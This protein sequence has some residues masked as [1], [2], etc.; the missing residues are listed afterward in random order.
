M[1]PRPWGAADNEPRPGVNNSAALCRAAAG[2]ALARV[3][4]HRGQRAGPCHAPRRAPSHAQARTGTPL[5]ATAAP[6]R[7]EHRGCPPR[8]C[9]AHPVTPSHP[10]VLPV[11]PSHRLRHFL[12]SAL[13]TGRCSQAALG[14]STL[15]LWGTDAK[16]APVCLP[17]KVPAP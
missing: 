4:H 14:S 11:N 7:P 10:R 8:P 5:A 6:E 13:Q 15:G 12:P 9:A 17:E 3:G 1:L 2:S 16:T